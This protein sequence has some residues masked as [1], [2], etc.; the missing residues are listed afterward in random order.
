MEFTL[1]F[2][3]LTAVAAIWVASRVLSSRLEQV[4]HPVDTL[5]G[6]A[7]VGLFA[8][9]IAAMVGD[10]VNPVTDPF[11]ILLVRAGVDTP[12]AATAAVA[13]LAWT[14]RR[15]LPVALDTLAPVALAGLAGWHGGCVWRGTCLGTVTDVPWA[16]AL[17]GSTAT[18]HPV[19]LYA[20]LGLAMVAILVARLP[21]RSW[22]PTGAAVTGSALMRLATEPIRPS[23]DGGPI[24]FY[25][26]A[27]GTGV[28]LMLI[29]PRLRTGRPTPTG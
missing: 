15:H 27:T 18:R 12:V 1:L 3:V 6:S 28:G 9:R 16:F 5:I 19:E 21:L 23:L 4:P 25:L 17:P 13:A 11:Q 8:G 29:G 7:S 26:V 14:F 24:W 20:A 22:L 2:A 10:G